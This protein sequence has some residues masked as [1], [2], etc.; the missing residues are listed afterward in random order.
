MQ[1]FNRLV[2]LDEIL[3]GSNGIEYCLLQ[4]YVG[5]VG[6]LALPKTS[7]FSD[8]FF[9]SLLTCLFF[10]LRCCLQKAIGKKQFVLQVSRY[11]ESSIERFH[12]T[13]TRNIT[14][15]L[16]TTHGNIACPQLPVRETK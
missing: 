7:C 14:F 11:I 1:L 16:H 6:I 2:D 15:T 8:A 4:A 10:T 13:N 5:K 3:Y 9:A 12:D